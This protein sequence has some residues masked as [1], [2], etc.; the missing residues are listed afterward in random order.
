MSV[1]SRFVA[2]VVAHL[3]MALSSP[4][5]ESR[6]AAEPITLDNVDNV[7]LLS[8]AKRDTRYIELG[9]GPNELLVTRHDGIEV[10]DDKEFKVIRRIDKDKVAL[11]AVS[12]D[13]SLT[14]WVQGKTAFIRDES[15][16]KTLEIEAGERPGRSAFSPDNQVF[17]IGNS[18]ITGSEGQGDS[19]LRVFD[20]KTGKLIRKLEIAIGIVGALRP[21]FSPDGSILAVGNRNHETKLFNTKTWELQHTL[22]KRMTQEIAFSPNGKTLATGYVDGTLALWDVQSG[23]ALHMAPSGCQ[24]IYSVTWNPSGDLLATA[25]PGKVLLW[26]AKAFRV[27]KD[28]MAVQWSRTIRFTTDGKRLMSIV[29]RN[30]TLDDSPRMIVWT[31]SAPAMKPGKPD[32]DVPTLE[33][34]GSLAIPAISLPRVALSPDGKRLVAPVKNYRLAAW[35]LSSGEQEW[36]TNEGQNYAGHDWQIYGLAFNPDGLTLASA[37]SDKTSKLWDATTGKLLATLKGHED[38]LEYLSYSPK[39]KYLFTST[40]KTWPYEK[41]GPVEARIWDARTGD[42]VAE[43]NGH[44]NTITRAEFSADETRV[45]TASADHTA[46]VWDAA[47]GKELHKF[48]LGSQIVTAVYSPD[49]KTILTSS[50]GSRNSY[51]RTAARRRSVNPAPPGH[52]VKLWDAMTGKELLSLSDSQAFYRASFNN[53]GDQI[54]TERRGLIT[55]WDT[56]TGKKLATRREPLIGS[57][58]IFS[59]SGEYFVVI[60]ADKPAELWS[61]AEKKQIGQMEIAKPLQTFFSRDG[62]T[63]YSLTRA[64]KFQS[65]SLAG[66]E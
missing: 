46:R 41:Y 6:Q 64:R 35:N 32:V 44:Y 39:G 24:E 52:I 26:D 9:P 8:E 37:S 54:L 3:V 48:D 17:V 61:V 51:A 40:G 50:S 38:R 58:A 43:L 55:Y 14:S 42:L 33:V 20:A 5:Q 10:V 66:L 63:F 1:D 56:E 16:G 22:P 15:T 60:V 18:I 36:V 57:K 13:R 34:A 11:F 28:L 7:G 65:W 47:S 2:V 31:T 53:V 23:E 49:G 45:L 4:A 12:R 19:V 29:V 59:P 30:D 25:G 62:Q 21:V 27:V